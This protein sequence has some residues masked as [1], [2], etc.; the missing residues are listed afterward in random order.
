MKI[1]LTKGKVYGVKIY[2]KDEVLVGVYLGEVEGIHFF[3]N[4]MR[5]ENPNYII[6]NDGQS[7]FKDELVSHMDY[8]SY[9]ISIIPKNKIQEIEDE[10]IKSGLIRIL[11][12]TKK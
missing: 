1:E 6:V 9:S 12:E 5:S 2:P 4:S 8:S 11:N 10:K 7:I 3:A